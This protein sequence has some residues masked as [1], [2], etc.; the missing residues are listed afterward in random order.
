MPFKSVKTK[1][2]LLLCKNIV[3]SYKIDYETEEYIS[4]SRDCIAK[5]LQVH[6]LPERRIKEINYWKN[7]IPYTMYVFPHCRAK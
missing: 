1:I 2:E 4:T 6:Q 3:V 5:G 7:K